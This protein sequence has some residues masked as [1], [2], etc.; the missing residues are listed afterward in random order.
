MMH[1][2]VIFQRVKNLSTFVCFQAQRHMRFYCSFV[3]TATSLLSFWV[4]KLQVGDLTNPMYY[5]AVKFSKSIITFLPQVIPL[6]ESPSIRNRGSRTEPSVQRWFMHPDSASKEVREVTAGHNVPIWEMNLTKF[7]PLPSLS[8][9]REDL[10]KIFLLNTL[11]KYILYIHTN[12]YECR[13]F[14]LNINLLYTLKW[15]V[16][17]LLQSKTLNH[18]QNNNI[19]KI[20]IRKCTSQQEPNSNEGVEISFINGFWNWRSLF[21]SIDIGKSNS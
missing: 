16:L 8:C 4:Y 13:I 21:C 5:C 1:F 17:N 12:L 2:V 20:Y 10:I 3:I 6:P 19:P 7:G 11:Q 18:P 9:H 14:L 15:M